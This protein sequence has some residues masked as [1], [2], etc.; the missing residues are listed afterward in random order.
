MS[1]Y[2]LFLI[3]KVPPLYKRCFYYW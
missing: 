3:E 1:S 2:I